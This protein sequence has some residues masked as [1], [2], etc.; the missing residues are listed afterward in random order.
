MEERDLPHFWSL[1]LWLSQLDGSKTGRAERIYRR[2]EPA[3]AGKNFIA[4]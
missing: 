1:T 2:L 4:R 3:A